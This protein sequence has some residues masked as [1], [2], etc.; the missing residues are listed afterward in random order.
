MDEH[1][2]TDYD[3]HLRAIRTAIAGL[4]LAVLAGSEIIAFGD[5]FGE[6]LL[7]LTILV[8]AYSF[9]PTLYNS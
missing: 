9:V 1:K 5:S 3:S 7:I 8:I 2:T 4:A 6:L